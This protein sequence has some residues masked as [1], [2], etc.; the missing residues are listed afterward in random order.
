MRGP[1][2]AGPS[3]ADWRLIDVDDLGVGDPA[4]DLAWPASWFAVGLIGASEWSG[5][6]AAYAAAGGVAL[7]TAGDPWD[8]LDPF[9]RAATV[10]RAASAVI[11]AEEEGRGLDEAEDAFVEA[12]VRMA[13]G[14][15]CGA[16]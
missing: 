15:S 1:V 3:E 16:R 13:V 2:N 8:V 5:L 10:H 12:C 7:P 9:A 6:L 14:A 11:R 4:W